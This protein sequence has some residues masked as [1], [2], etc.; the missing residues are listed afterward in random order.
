MGKRTS[1]YYQINVLLAVMMLVFT[2]QSLIPRLLDGDPYLL[3]R[4]VSSGSSGYASFFFVFLILA[5]L[6]ETT[7]T[8]YIQI[9]TLT[10]VGALVVLFLAPRD[11]GG[12]L[13]FV[14]AAVLAYK[15]G[16]MRD[17][18]FLKL[19]VLFS[20]LIVTRATSVFVNHNAQMFR[21]IG[22]FVISA[23]FFP[24]LFWVFED[25]LRRVAREKR[26]LE[27]Q[28]QQ[29]LPFVEFGRNVSGIVHDFK[30][31]LGLF[32]MFGQLLRINRG[33]VLSDEQIENYE[34]YVTRFSK[35]IERILTVTRLT[36]SIGPQEIKLTELVKAVMYVFESDL[37]L[38]RKIVFSQHFP[39]EE[40]IVVSEAAEI[41][42]ILENLVR[43][44]CEALIEH[45]GEDESA[46]SRAR[47][48]IN[49]LEE[50]EAILEI[51]DN[52]PGIPACQMCPLNDCLTC[53]LFEV[54]KTTKKHGT[55]LGL[56]NV[57]AA[58][59]R[60]GA[61]LQMVSEPGGGVLVRVAIPKKQ[62][63]DVGIRP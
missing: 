44:G 18:L 49:V 27:E 17:H 40:V 39:K 6:R 29:N 47:L 52:G 38:K 22:Q 53:D 33:E 54:G 34:H 30:N 5:L 11:M 15:Y 3:K 46:F 62:P 35:R 31:D 45:Y 42:T 2:L 24:I 32:S 28:A 20:L 12:D 60:I 63:V 37:S 26:S 55:G 16:F 13:L 8:R 59:Y 10:V 9:V 50:D 21:A 4:I 7:R 25:E 61:D 36:H 57:Q 14:L 58:A 23:S 41:V 51:E 1:R 43:N 56:V 48:S 19:L